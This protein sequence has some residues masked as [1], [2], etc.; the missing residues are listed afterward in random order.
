[1]KRDGETGQHGA[2]KGGQNGREEGELESKGRKKE[3]KI[4]REEKVVVLLDKMRR[5]IVK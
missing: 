2:G 4:E 1:M 5:K 3:R